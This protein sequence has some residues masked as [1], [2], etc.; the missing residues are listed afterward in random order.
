MYLSSNQEHTH[1]ASSINR[2][3]TI[4]ALWDYRQEKVKENG[5]LAPCC[6]LG[7]RYIYI[8]QTEGRRSAHA[9]R[10]CSDTKDVATSF[11]LL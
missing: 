2:E 3:E 6:V 5:L 4:H 10:G 7:T 9:T 1:T 8:L 11:A